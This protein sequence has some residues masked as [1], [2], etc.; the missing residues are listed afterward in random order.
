MS[1]PGTATVRP[2][3]PPRE[4]RT[5]PPPRPKR[6]LRER[7]RIGLVIAS[8]FVLVAT[9]TAWGLYRNVTAGIVT[10]DLMLGSSSD[11]AQNILLVG[12]DSRTDASGNPLPDEVLRRLHAGPNT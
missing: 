6:S 3:T 11:G 2:R 4:W 12:V 5:A 10:T 1:G 9:G 8:A 7:M